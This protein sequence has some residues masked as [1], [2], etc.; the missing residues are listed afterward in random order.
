MKRKKKLQARSSSGVCDAPH[1]RTGRGTAVSPST[2]PVSQPNHTTSHPTTE[3]HIPPPPR[4]ARKQAKPSRIK[5]TC[6]TKQLYKTPT[7][8]CCFSDSPAVPWSNCSITQQHIQTDAQTLKKM[9]LLSPSPP[10]LPCLGDVKTNKQEGT[11]QAKWNGKRNFKQDR[12]L[13]YAMPPTYLLAGAPPC[14]PAQSPL[15]QPH[16][17]SHPT[18]ETHIPPPLQQKSKQAKPSRIRNTRSTK[19]LHKAVNTYP[20]VL[21]LRFSSSALI[22]LLVRPT[23]H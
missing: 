7:P 8:P 4:Q 18:T 22:Q 9:L 20:L 14:R 17:T 3:T 21:L 1:V 15:T 12:C 2:V 13:V 19:Q 10:S 11:L 16:H 5:N 23:T 6:S